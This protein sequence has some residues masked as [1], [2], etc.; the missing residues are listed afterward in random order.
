MTARQ[1]SHHAAP[2]NVHSRRGGS[3]E[4][5]PE[6][7]ATF[8]PFAQFMRRN[9]QEWPNTS[10]YREGIT[11]AVALD[12]LSLLATNLNAVKA[13]KDTREVLVRRWLCIKY[14]ASRTGQNG[15]PRF[16]PY[17]TGF[18]SLLTQHGRI[19]A[20]AV[21]TAMTNSRFAARVVKAQAE[22]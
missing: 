9:R 5:Y 18:E 8:R 4:L 7:A 11:L 2:V 15:T 12:L 6:T 13:V 10:L 21:A 20:A 16:P 1:I 22:Q 19:P 17:A 14:V 3:E